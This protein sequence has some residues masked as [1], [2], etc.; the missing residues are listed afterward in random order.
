M[1]ARRQTRSK[2]KGFTYPYPRP[3][4]TVDVVVFA[5]GAPPRRGAAPSLKVLL[6]RRGKAPFAGRWALPG[7]FVDAM[8]D[9]PVAAAR[10]LEEETGL[11]AELGPQVGAYGTPGRDPRGH[12]VSVAYLTWLAGGPAAVQGQDDAVDA[13]WH[14]A[15]KPPPLAFDH[16]AVLADS[17]HRLESLC[18]EQGSGAGWAQ[19]LPRSF[20]VPDAASLHASARGLPLGAS[21]S[22]SVRRAV[23]AHAQI[24]ELKPQGRLLRFRRTA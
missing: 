14:D 17:V 5:A 13:R 4:V 21:L 18:N 8:E 2:P 6:I 3:A 23:R 20:G 11:Q 12:T 24:R 19:L 22:G 10:E 7:G 1:A 15:R 16:K 9:L